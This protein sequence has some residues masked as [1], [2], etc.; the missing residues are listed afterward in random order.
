[1]N[2]PQRSV[3]RSGPLGT[4]LAI[5][6]VVVVTLMALA[7][8]ALAGVSDVHLLVRSGSLVFAL[9]LVLYLRWEIKM[10]FPGE[11][12]LRVEV[13]DDTIEF[14]MPNTPAEVFRRADIN[15]IVI[16]EDAL[17]TGAFEAYGP[18]ET[19]LGYWNTNWSVK[20]PQSAMRVLKRHGYPYALRTPMYGKRLF[21][22]R[23]GRPVGERS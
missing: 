7:L 10:T 17:G 4:A 11:G 20:P 21:Y 18:G 12:R 16:E 5:L 8:F 19:V 3:I 22:R 14:K 2:H 9:V 23:A 1:M 13:D 6:W 15:L